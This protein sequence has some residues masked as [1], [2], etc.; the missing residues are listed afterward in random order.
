MD[1]RYAA[2]GIWVLDMGLRPFDELAA[3]EKFS[4][5]SG[6]LDL[7]LVRADFMNLRVERLDPAVECFQRKSTDPVSPVRKSFCLDE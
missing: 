1:L 4:E 3:L 5:T 7:S 2:E 6:C